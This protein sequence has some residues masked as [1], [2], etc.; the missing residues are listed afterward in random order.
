MQKILRLAAMSDTTGGDCTAD[1]GNDT[2]A[3]S[4][5]GTITVASTLPSIANTV[6]IDGTE[7]Q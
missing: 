1:T 5:R 7:A 2:I 3:F 6:E 4:V